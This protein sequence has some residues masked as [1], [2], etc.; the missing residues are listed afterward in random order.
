MTNLSDS[1]YLFFQL[2]PNF[3]WLSIP[4]HVIQVEST[5]NEKGRILKKSPK[6][7]RE[8]NICLD[9]QK[10]PKGKQGQLN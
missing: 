9:I 2:N 1:D 6:M 7:K 10:K 5:K 8:Y 4:N 3:D